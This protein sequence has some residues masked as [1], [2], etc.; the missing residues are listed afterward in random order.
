MS[1]N[2]TIQLLSALAA[3]GWIVAGLDQAT[4]RFR[5]SLFYAVTGGMFTGGVAALL[6]TGGAP[7]WGSTSQWVLWVAVASMGAFGARAIAHIVRERVILTR[8]LR[9]ISLE[10]AVDQNSN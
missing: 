3:V 6:L 5:H 2:D 1:W 9:E 8:E 7:G 4:A 10:S